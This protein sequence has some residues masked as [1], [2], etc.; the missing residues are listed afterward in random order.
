MIQ[1]TFATVDIGGTNTRIGFSKDLKTI[2]YIQRFPTPPTQLELTQ[3][4]EATLLQQTNIE[5]VA[6]GI[7]GTIDRKAKKILR[8]PNINELDSLSFKELV[9]NID[10]PVY[11]ENDAAL[12]VLGETHFGEGKNFNTVAHVTISTGVGAALVI[13]KKLVNTR[14]NSEPG[15]HIINIKEQRDW[16]SYSSGLSFNKIYGIHPAN[17]DN[18]DIWKEYG[19]TLAVGLHNLFRFWAP[20]VIILG[21]GVTKKSDRFLNSTIIKLKKLLSIEEINIRISKLDDQN[22]LLGGLKLIEQ[23]ISN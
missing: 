2:F 16:E 3:K 14:F 19:E 8:T 15:H 13:N 9:P 10:C 4:V 12:A 5:G 1:K 18:E 7:A 11:I 21:G 17:C 20:D 6:I 23:N 22:G